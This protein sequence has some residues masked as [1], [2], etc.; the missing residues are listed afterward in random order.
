VGDPTRTDQ[1][2]DGPARDRPS[3][4]DLVYEVLRSA[5]RPLTVQ[6]VFD[7][8]NRRAPITTR[9]PKATVRTALSQGPMLVGLGD[10][11]YGYLP[12]L[13]RGSLLRLPLTEKKPAH[14]PLVFPGEVLQA[15]WPA[16]FE[17]Q[18]RADRRPVRLRLPAGEEVALPLE[19][20]GQGVWGSAMPEPLRRLLV[21]RRAGAG[22]ALLL[23]LVDA[24]DGGCDV[25]FEAQRERDAG[26][27]AARNEA[28]AEAAHRLLAGSR[29][30]GVPAWELATGLLARGFYR[31]VVA[32]DTLEAV[33]LADS[34]FARTE[35]GIWLLAGGAPPP[36][37]AAFAGLTSPVDPLNMRR[38]MER[39]MA[40]LS[41][42]LSE[43]SFGSPEEANAFLEQ[44][45]AGGGP[46][47]RR[48]ATP[49]ERAQEVMY[50][51]WD[52]PSPRERV[53]LA[54]KALAVS[55]DCADAYVLLAE[56]TA[57]SPEEAA[58][59]YARGVAAGERALGPAAF[60]EDA[61]H[62]WGL[63]E[64]RPYMR[65]RLGLAQARWALGTRPEAV[66]DAW[67]L[68]RL[69]PGDNQGVRYLLLRWL[70]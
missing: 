2:T 35:L 8:V 31:A 53:R 5:D 7:A 56:E 11:R 59:L 68:L 4:A 43:R 38:A 17:I 12:H 55:G 18:K 6:E 34:R 10:G 69:N 52:A 50:D 19:F 32:P 47:R 20:L 39:T 33:L 3:N 51:A 46:P 60:G 65:A 49:P 40:D 22:D 54:R 23:R 37:P 66:A 27:V 64:T 25:R 15:L 62:F 45:T 41:A 26:A 58:D 36:P 21:E 44:V 1:Q 57:R 29:Y 28:L 9:N 24:P 63:V 48:A 61:G 67:D 30:D 42:L 16:F 13:V 14:H 70:L